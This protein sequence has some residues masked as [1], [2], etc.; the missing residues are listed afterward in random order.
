MDIA[1][2]SMSHAQFE[3]Q[4]SV[5]MSNMSKAMDVAE[6]QMQDMVEMLQGAISVPESTS[7]VGLGEL[8]DVKA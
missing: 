7:P 1:A 5:A 6:M 3:L 8:I 2:I 4:Q